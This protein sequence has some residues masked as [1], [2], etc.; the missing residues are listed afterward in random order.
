MPKFALFPKSPSQRP[1][2]RS[3]YL[4]GVDGVP[5]RGDIRYADDVIVCET[6]TP[7]ALGLSLLWEVEGF[8][9]VQLETTRLPP[10]DEPYNLHAELARHR[11][12]RISTKREEWGLYDYPGMNEVAARIDGAR[13]RFVQSLAA[14][15]EPRRAA[16]L[17]DEALA[18]SLWASEELCGFHAS[19]FLG[20]RQMSGGLSKGVLGAT[21]PA[22]LPERAVGKALAKVFDFVRV[23]LPWREIQPEERETT[24]DAL[25]ACLKRCAAAG[26]PVRGGPVLNFGVQFVPDWMFAWESDYEAI[27]AFAREHV[28]RTVQRYASQVSSWIV[29]SGLHADNVF[30]FNF[31]QIMDMTRLAVN[32]TRQAAPRAH[33]VLD[34]VQPWGEYYARNQRSIPPLLYAE[35]AQQSGIAF[36]AFGV[37]FL[38]GIDA[39][40]YQVRDFMQV[41]SLIDRLAG[42]GKP[43]HITAAAVPSTKQVGGTWR[44]AW[45]EETQAEWL[46]TFGTIALSKPYVESVCLCGLTDGA[47]AGVPSGGVLRD[48]LSAK[49]SFE[50]L[51]EWR[52][53]SSAGSRT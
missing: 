18:E 53:A 38:F 10:R 14:L 42:L 48:D 29:A 17:A 15:N 52:R 36:D 1:D 22:G 5:V 3:M 33:I 51:A 50:K 13:D 4:V 40:G 9:R 30:P 34:L 19:I 11:L 37:Q 47:C 25:D 6:H 46:T 28:R 26:L 41:S 2:V 20:R 21:V 45:S 12:M 24:Y 27:A 49:L 8:G 23:P 16:R 44:R 43:L 39:E 35:M 32:T 7:E 31:E